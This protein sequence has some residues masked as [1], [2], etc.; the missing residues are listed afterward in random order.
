M[1]VA[2]HKTNGSGG[3]PKV[4]ELTGEY[5]STR[6]SNDDKSF[7]IG[8][9]RDGTIVKGN[10]DPEKLLPGGSY[11]FLGKWQD[12]PKYGRQFQFQTFVESEPHT[13]HGVIQY[14][15]RNTE[16]VGI[17]RA[18][19]HAL[20]DAF[21]P[22]KVIQVLKRNPETVAAI[23]PRVSLDMAKRA[24]QQ[25]I[26]VEKFEQT[27]IDL[28]DLFAG[29]GFPNDLIDS[30]VRKFG[31]LGPKRLRHDPFTLLV[32][33]MP[34]CGFLRVDALYQALGLPLDR[35]KRQAICVWHAMKSDMSGSVW[36]RRAWIESRVRELVSGELRIDK[37]IA[38][39]VRARLVE[40]KVVDGVE[41]IATA[42]DARD[43]RQVCEYLE[44]IVSGA[45]LP[46]AIHWP[47]LQKEFGDDSI[48]DHQVAG[49]VAATSG[50]VGLLTGLP[51][52][53]KSFSLARLVGLLPLDRV[54]LA[55]PTGRA[56]VRIMESLAEYGHDLH[57]STIH[58]LLGISRNGHDGEGWGFVH[59]ENNPLPVDYLIIDECFPAGTL[60][61][62]PDGKVAIESL[63][64]GDSILNVIGI[65][66]VVA[67]KKTEVTDAAIVHTGGKKICCSRSHR[68]LT[69]RGWVSAAEL[70]PGDRI[71]QTESTMRNVRNRICSESPNASS[72]ILQKGMCLQMSP[73]GQD[74]W[75][76]KE[77]LV[78]VGRPKSQEGDGKNKDSESNVVTCCS[79]KNLS[80]ATF[81][82][83]EA[84]SSWRE[85]N[86]THKSAVG[87]ACGSRRQLDS[88]ACDPS[89][90]ENCRIS[91]ELQGG[92]G[93]QNFEDCYRSGW[94]QPL[95]ELKKTSGSQERIE[96]E[97][98]R[99]DRVEILKQD[100][101]RL[102]Q[103][104][105]A[106]GK[107]RFYDIQAARHP[108]FSVEGLIVHNCSMIPASLMASLLSAVRPGACIL[109][110]GDPNQ[111][112]PVG[113]GRPFLDMIEAGLPH[114]H[115]S[116]VHRFAGR[117]A[118][119]CKSI[120]DGK[121]WQP[122]AQVDLEPADG[123][124]ENLR[125]IERAVPAMQ[126][127]A[128]KTVIDRVVN[129]RGFDPVWDMQVLCAV[130]DKSPVCRKNLNATLQEM[131]N[132]GGERLERNPFRVGD[133]V[134]A[135]KNGFRVEHW[136]DEKPSVLMEHYVANGEIG[137]VENISEHWI[138]VR[139]SGKESV[140]RFDRAE[141]TE[142]D[143]AYAITCHKAQGAGF[144]VVIVMIDSTGGASFVCSR[145]HHYTA[146]SRASKLC[147]TIGKKSVMNEHCRKVD[148]ERRK[149][150]L[151]E[152]IIKWLRK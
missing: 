16:R 102:D 3:T 53:G 127:Q 97:F 113:A 99:V 11:R 115:L 152:G 48:T 32:H 86:G 38:L 39:A 28:L 144:P 31:V 91:N 88:R 110:I 34:G 7:L 63:N 122:S 81:N 133:K 134:M 46:N 87:V 50:Q 90:R 109:F 123:F 21:G 69:S 105:D 62:T 75:G 55:A 96:V 1:A 117:I 45:D 131:L 100:D 116:E 143:L 27:K 18:T 132:P 93:E 74:V 9:L 108:S 70:G 20:V 83:M 30:C 40:V 124:P 54:A 64:P 6:W 125:H 51:G 111:L 71:A 140:I 104:R 35:L 58:S 37:A 8:S 151:T 29:R 142:I 60:V 72:E 121:Q 41:W 103:Y 118:Q 24:A 42:Q 150:F 2:T 84:D 138:A 119:V 98:S 43:E 145:S 101:P 114:G 56:A 22:D 139:F 94:I 65:D 44:R 15:L 106:D 66:T 23:V 19:A 89:G 68:F 12:H 13:Y 73:Q 61:D 120:N 10:A 135:L 107:L 67:T 92:P 26:A 136:E 128:M 5:A 137:K 148:T 77:T 126:V 82:W 49:L 79:K 147:I 4:E 112:P 17:G 141:W 33:N 80:N 52:T 146:I 149:T 36:F 59:N 76:R 85:R 57:A 95:G 78:K 130:N 129:G 25:L 14:L 47:Q